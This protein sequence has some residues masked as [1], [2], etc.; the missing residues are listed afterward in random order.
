MRSR[1]LTTI[2]IAG[3]FVH[4]GFSS[5]VTAQD[6]ENGRPRFV[7]KVTGGSGFYRMKELNNAYLAT[8]RRWSTID[9]G[10]D[11]DGV[12]K[13]QSEAPGK[14][15][16]FGLSAMVPL[17]DVLAAGIQMEKMS[18]G[19]VIT[20]HETRY[21]DWFGSFSASFVEGDIRAR[22]Q[23]VEAVGVFYPK[24]MTRSANVFLQVGIGYGKLKMNSSNP[25]DLS[26]SDISP[27]ASLNIG[28]ESRRFWGAFRLQATAGVRWLRFEGFDV[29]GGSRVPV[30]D[31]NEFERTI[32]NIYDRGV[33]D[34]SGASLRVGLSIVLI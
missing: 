24:K 1:F 26:A 23:T 22:A 12:D 2:V 5:A 34:F 11:I 20:L 6:Q 4:T 27:A 15:F 21:S 30:Q 33:V 29:S 28:V 31:L 7:V 13:S 19:F 17:G 8:A 14:G 25:M 10:Y 3:A 18:D 16:D 32:L 9:N